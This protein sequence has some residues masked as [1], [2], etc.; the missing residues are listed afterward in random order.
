MKL[1]KIIMFM[2]P[3]VLFCTRGVF[4]QDHIEQPIGPPPQTLAYQGTLEPAKIYHIPANPKKG[5]YWSYY[6]GT[7]RNVNEKRALYVE[8]NNDGRTGVPIK[9]HQYWASIKCEQA[10]VDYTNKLE[11]FALVPVF[12]RPALENGNN[13][14][15][16][17]L[18][19]EVIEQKVDSLK[20]IDLQ[21]LAMIEDAQSKIRENGHELPDKFTLWGFSAAGDF[22]T[23]MALIHPEKVQAL[24]AGGLGGFPIL[25]LASLDNTTLNYPVGISDFDSLFGK[26]FNAQAFKTI[27]MK[28]FQGGEDE[29]DSV[30]EGEE[31]ADQT[32]F[33]SDSYSYDQCIFVNNAF[34][35]KPVDRIARVKK[36]YQDFGIKNFD[37]LI[38]PGIKH[39]TDPFEDQVFEFLKEYG[40]DE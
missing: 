31:L 20:R 23:R 12:P 40:I 8:P 29:N 17:A 30:A 5:F 18:T 6:L 21:L 34:G 22:V 33:L 25:P 2:T 10:M 24:V 16:H 4:A 39:K 19:R 36:I 1:S 27:P 14:Y 26:P 35:E 11:T 37:Y 9:T 13:L 38:I 32:N 28:F 15:V 7:P 3:L